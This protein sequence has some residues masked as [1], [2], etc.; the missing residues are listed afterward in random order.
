M[1]KFLASVGKNET[2]LF[3]GDSLIYHLLVDGG[4]SPTYWAKIQTLYSKYP[5]VIE[6]SVGGQT[7]TSANAAIDGN[8]QTYSQASVVTMA[9]GINDIAAGHSTS[10]FSTQMQAIIAK[11]LAR[12]AVPVIPTITYSTVYDVTAFNAVITGTLWGIAGVRQGPDLYTMVLNN[13][14]YLSGDGVHLS[15]PAGNTA[16]VAEWAT[17]FSWLYA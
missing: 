14:S 1:T 7:A 11:I 4:A 12:K 2:I 13:P 5:N 16:A 9:W 17:A 10:T 3:A 8:L 15:I 6:L